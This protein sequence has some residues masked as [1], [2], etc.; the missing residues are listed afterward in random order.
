MIK[1]NKKKQKNK[2]RIRTCSLLAKNFETQIT[3][4]YH[5]SR[6]KCIQVKFNHKIWSQIFGNG[7]PNSNNA[8]FVEEYKQ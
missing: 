2:T 8:S 7:D 4:S 1:D 5:G 6:K 3:K